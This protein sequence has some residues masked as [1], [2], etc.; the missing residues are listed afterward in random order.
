MFNNPIGR[1]TLLLQL[2]LQANAHGGLRERSA[3]METMDWSGGG[4]WIVEWDDA[5]EHRFH[6]K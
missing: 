1:A 6:K 3:G 2:S 4:H 5:R